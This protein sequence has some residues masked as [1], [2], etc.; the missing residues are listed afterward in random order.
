MRTHSHMQSETCTQTQNIWIKSWCIVTSGKE[1][2]DCTG[3]GRL[4]R[5]PSAS[6]K[7]TLGNPSWSKQK[8]HN[9]ATSNTQSNHY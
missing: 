7:A 3:T 5:S 6:T 8:M 1:S 2:S 9:S 4:K